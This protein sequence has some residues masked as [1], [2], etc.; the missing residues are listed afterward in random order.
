MYLFLLF[1]IIYRLSISLL[2]IA[3]HDLYYL[4]I[5]IGFFFKLASN[6]SILNAR[7]CTTI[8]NMLALSHEGIK[9]QQ[10]QHFQLQVQLQQQQQR[11]Q[12][13]QL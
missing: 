12:T 7:Y 13:E 11:Q 3:Y 8:C 6:F 9:Q 2:M 1:T 5:L 10:T 4:P